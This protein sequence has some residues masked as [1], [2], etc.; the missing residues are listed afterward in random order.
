VI[1]I[2][3]IDRLIYGGFIGP[4]LLS[5][6][7]AE[8]VL[9]MQFLW[10]F[11]DRILGKGIGFF[12]IMELLFYMAVK[13]IPMAIPLTILISSVMVFG[14]MSEKYELS[15]I[16][17]AG[18]SLLRTMRPGINLGIATALFSLL[19]SNF[20]VPL[21]NFEFQNRF[22]KIK[23]TKPT[24]TFEEGIFS[25]D[26]KG[27]SIRIGKK[28]P[29]GKRI[30]DI[31]IEDHTNV[32]KSLVNV[33]IASHGEMFTTADGNY[34][35]MNLRDGEQSKELKRKKSKE[36]ESRS[37]PVMRTQ[38]EEWTKVFDMSGFS[39]NEN[40]SE[41]NRN[42]YDLLNSVQLI[43][44][45]DSLNNKIESRLKSTHIY[46]TNK[47][48]KDN[49][50]KENKELVKQDSLSKQSNKQDQKSTS[51]LDRSKK[52]QA[53]NTGIATKRR[54][55]TKGMIQQK[56]D[57]SGI[58]TMHT[59]L[60]TIDSKQASKLLKIAKPKIT[61]QKDRVKRNENNIKSLEKYKKQHIYKL[62][63]AYSW[64]LVCIIFLFIGAPL[65]SIIRKGGYGY[66]LLFAI[67]FYMIFM[68]TVIFGQKLLKTD[69]INP[70]FA[71]WLPC[72]LLMPIALYLTHKAVN[73]S[74]INAFGK[75]SALIERIK[76]KSR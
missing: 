14:N 47:K 6:F 30:Q 28:D 25:D 50:A 26:F 56:K 18:V 58:D 7:V 60:Q 24:L 5:F 35:I 72:L 46:A 1:R 39:F 4:Y 10:K 54:R 57:L 11:I 29:D 20:L 8:F 73:D 48:I 13:L 71:A 59:F 61:N 63:E 44:G 37:Y 66:P 67:L 52:R 23:R 27:F 22:N 38:F 21:A 3:K 70:I 40:L 12:Q 33:T 64:A 16:K 43:A 62:N 34:F 31:I 17:S 55:S 74:K 49:K 15:S 65:G 51:A 53:K 41:L 45:I 75:F 76:S 36:T 32:D 2:K 68:I 42:K 69:S 9:I 19:C